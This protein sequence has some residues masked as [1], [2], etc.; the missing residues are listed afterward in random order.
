[1][2][3]KAYPATKWLAAKW[4]AA[5]PSARLSGIVGDAAHA[6]DGGYHIS[7]QDQPS[8]NY[9]V[10]DYSLDRLGPSDAAA[11]VDMTMN[12]SDMIRV[13]RRL[14]AAAAN[15]SDPRLLGKVRAFNGTFNGR[16]AIRIEVR[17]YNGRGA[18]VYSATADHLWHVHLEIHRR[19]VN[20]QSVMDGIYSVIRGES[21]SA[22]KIRRGIAKPAAPVAPAKPIADQSPV[23]A[24]VRHPA[25]LVLQRAIN[26]IFGV[27]LPVDG[28]FGPKT[29]FYVRKLQGMAGLPQGNVVTKELW[30]YIARRYAA[31][32]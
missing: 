29:L 25:V 2:T 3:T 26:K 31:T 20:S 5:I 13:S 22:Y 7:R 12:T 17:Q 16:S 8:W 18:G 1:M 4:D 32:K 28:V 14:A 30:S 21:L 6:R 15:K 11:A 19:Y 9:S 23:G 27:S 10:A 24:G